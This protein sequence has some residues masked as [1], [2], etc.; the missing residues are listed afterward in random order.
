MRTKE[1]LKRESATLR[2]CPFCNCKAEFATNKSEQILLQHY[3]DLG[4]NCPARCEI[5]CDTF[6]FGR[7]IWNKRNC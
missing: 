4:V 1:E 2:L 3:P 5:Y 6:D 7:E